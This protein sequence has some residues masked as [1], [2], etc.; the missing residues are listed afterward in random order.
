M[1]TVGFVGLGIMGRPMLRNLLKAGHTVVAYGRTPAK[2]DAAVADG[3]QRGTSNADVGARAASSSPCCPTALKSKKSSS[4]RTESSPAPSPAPHH[5]HELHQPARLAKNRRGLRAQKASI[6]S[7]RP[8]VAASPRPSTAL[9]PSWSAASRMSSRKPSPSSSAWAPASRSPGRSAPAIPPSSPI[10]SWLPATSPPWARRLRSPRAADSILKLS[11]TPSKP[12]S[13]A[14]PCSTP[15]GPCSSR[16]TSS[17]ASKSTF[18]RKT[19]ATRSRPRKPIN[20]FL[21]LTAHVQQMLSSL[22][23]NG[24]GDLDHS[25]IATFVE[26]ASHVEVK[27]PAA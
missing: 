13:P 21:P 14:A 20:V 2:L 11:S 23:A 22:I 3:A 18:T 19:C 8:S 9:S 25:A 12:D 5:R 7:T 26:T 17:P 6:S 1:A 10:K 24:K 16:A 15:R 27:V 4:A